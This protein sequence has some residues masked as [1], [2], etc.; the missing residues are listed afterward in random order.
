MRCG[1]ESE[2]GVAGKHEEESKTR[3]YCGVLI[4]EEE[5]A[6]A[7]MNGIGKKLGVSCYT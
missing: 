2:V 1:V 5:E 4:I 3:V 7:F 6:S